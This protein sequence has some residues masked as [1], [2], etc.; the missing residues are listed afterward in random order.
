MEELKDIV[1]QLRNVGEEVL[2][3]IQ[4]RA[5]LSTLFDILTENVIPRYV[6]DKELKEYYEKRM[7]EVNKFIQ[8][9]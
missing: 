7:E 2:E 9:V 4:H 8:T 5:K 1:N 3:T 6:S